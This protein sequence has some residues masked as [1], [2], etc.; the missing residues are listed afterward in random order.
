[1]WLIVDCLLWSAGVDGHR[2]ATFG[3][4]C[5][6]CRNIRSLSS[7]SCVKRWQRYLLKNQPVE[8]ETN[9]TVQNVTSALSKIYWIVDCSSLLSVVVAVR[10]PS[11]MR[12]FLS[13]SFPEIIRFWA[14]TISFCFC[15]SIGIEQ[16]TVGLS[17][18]LSG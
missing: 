17:T 14:Q 9:T 6:L 4:I 2:Q 18:K 15:L 11:S 1:M 12:F 8:H 5:F 10:S 3:S 13:P 7:L 16:G